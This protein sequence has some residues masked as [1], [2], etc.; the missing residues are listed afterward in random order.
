MFDLSK[1]ERTLTPQDIQAQADSR[2][3]LAYLL[4][5]DWYSLRFIE[6]NKPVPEAILA[7]RAVARSKVIR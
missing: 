5:T 6:E 4:S 3:A 1:L 7:A 2:E